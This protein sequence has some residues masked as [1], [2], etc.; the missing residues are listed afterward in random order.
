MKFRSTVNVRTETL[1]WTPDR[2][3][4]GRLEKAL[5]SMKCYPPC[6]WPDFE[7][8]FERHMNTADR[9]MDEIQRRRELDR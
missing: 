9:I 6:T 5:H 2:E 8:F 1:L 3:L 7:V 4:Q